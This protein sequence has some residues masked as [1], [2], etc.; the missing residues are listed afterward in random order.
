MLTEASRSNSK[1]EHQLA[2]IDEYSFVS[3]KSIEELREY[4]K[5]SDFWAEEK[6]IGVIQKNLNI[7]VLPL[8]KLYN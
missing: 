4:I 7:R 1:N 6:S 8:N 3:N 5:T 2:I